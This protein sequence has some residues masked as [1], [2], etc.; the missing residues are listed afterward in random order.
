MSLDG[1]SISGARG[2]G[3]GDSSTWVLKLAAF[4]ISAAATCGSDVDLANLRS[5]AA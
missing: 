5:V 3:S 1:G 2:L 4:S